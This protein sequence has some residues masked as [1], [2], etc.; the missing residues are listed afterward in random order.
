MKNKY[1]RNIIEGFLFFAK[2]CF[3]FMCMLSF[4]IVSLTEIIPN[5]IENYSNLTLYIFMTILLLA[6]AGAIH[7]MFIEFKNY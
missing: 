7:I 3:Y 1:L 2:S 6:Q 4:V 5:I